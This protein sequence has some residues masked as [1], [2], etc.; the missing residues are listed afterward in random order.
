MANKITCPSCDAHT[1]AV[2]RAA[3]GIDAAG[4][5]VHAADFTCPYCK[6]PL[7]DSLT[8]AACEMWD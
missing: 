6:A 7:P 8:T 2:W 4:R 1:S 5:F 3:I